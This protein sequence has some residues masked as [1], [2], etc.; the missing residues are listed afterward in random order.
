[1][2]IIIDMNVIDV[3]MFGTVQQQI[4][5]HVQVMLVNLHIGIK[6]E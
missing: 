4:Q 3:G 2:E 1:M 5:R 6:R